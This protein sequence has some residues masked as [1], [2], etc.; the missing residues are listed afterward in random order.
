MN[1]FFT[2]LI[3]LVLFAFGSSFFLVDLSW[4]SCINPPANL[5][6]WWSGNNNP[7]DLVGLNHG[8]LIHGA[9]YNANGKVSQAFS[10]DGGD[11]AVR[12]P[13]SALDGAYDKLTIDA[14]VYPLSHGEAG[15]EGLGKT[16]LSKT[17]HDGFAL[18]IYN[19]LVQADLRTT[20][21]HFIANFTSLELP[22]DAWSHVAITYDSTLGEEN[23]KGYYN[24]TLLGTSDAMGT[25]TNTLNASTCL[26]IGNEPE[27]DPDTQE[28]DV[29]HYVISNPRPILPGP[30]G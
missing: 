8:T 30:V 4:T 18:R 7:F 23:I 21:G 3:F 12:I 24:G 27:V 6:S 14:W 17:E 1:C 28:C 10:F 15:T 19:G 20:E 22:L 11:D 25:V 29:F 16:I 2:K 26:M 5:V 9:S 13:A